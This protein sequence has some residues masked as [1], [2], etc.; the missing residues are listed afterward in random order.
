MPS[1]E[2]P[3]QL[4]AR[5]I[6]RPVPLRERV[7]QAMQ[8]LIISRQL[9][10]GQHL[11][12]SELAE[13][14]G[15]SRQPIREALQL[16]N[17]EGWVDLRP[18]YGAFVHAPTD[19]EVDQLLVVRAA[20]EAESARLAALGADEEGV[21]KLRKLCAQGE[22]AVEAD[23]IDGMVA[24]NA[25]LHRCVTELS[26][27]QVLLDFV[28]QVDRRVRWYYQPIARHRG[29]KSWQEHAKLIDAI[30]KGDADG[31]AKIMREH[32]ER[33]R[34]SY[35]EQRANDPEPEEVPVQVRSRR[36]RTAPR[37]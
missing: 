4:A 34:Q 7:Y 36:R 16:L 9:A 18:G 35:L 29:S 13:M 23:D 25:D 21:A 6:D 31:A 37:G 8:E 30:E 12:E 33:T 14:L 27:N 2:L 1:T 10:P 11:V 24:A 20:L 32:T 22:A 17:S 5:R 28:S 3:Q 26:G 19:T 15:V